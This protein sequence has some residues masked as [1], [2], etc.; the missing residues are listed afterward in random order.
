[1]KI[2]DIRTKVSFLKICR[3]GFFQKSRIGIYGKSQ[4]ERILY[5]L[6]CSYIEIFFAS[7]LIVCVAVILN[8]CCNYVA[9]S[10]AGGVAKGGP[11]G[12][13]YIHYL[14]LRESSK[15]HSI[16]LHFPCIF[17]VK[18]AVQFSCAVRLNMLFNFPA[19]FS[20]MCLSV[21]LRSSSE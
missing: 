5:F 14:R 6:I 2:S 4:T 17:R 18:I 11:L 21:L 3:T 13:M 7:I 16:Y 9:Y 1:M 10:N 20:L 19:Q 12:I 15:Q 8:I